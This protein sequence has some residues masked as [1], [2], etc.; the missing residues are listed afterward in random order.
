MFNLRTIVRAA[1]LALLLAPAGALAAPQDRV[2]L[3]TGEQQVGQVLGVASGQVQ[4]AIATGATTGRLSFRLEAISRVEAEPPAAFREGVAAFE[5]GDFEKALRTLQPVA[6]GF[7]GLPTDWARQAAALLG[8]LYVEKGDLARAEAA[9]TDYAKLYGGGGATGSLRTE[10]GAARLALAKQDFPG[11]RRRLEPVVT[12]ALKDPVKISRADAAA[13]GQACLLLGQI[14]ERAGDN[15]SALT[16]Y[17]RTV[18]LFYQDR[19]TVTAAQKAAD[20]LRAAHPGLM[21]PP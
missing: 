5:A 12:A 3:K 15:P 9:Y 19:A 13:A 11:A 14:A 1:G 10:V 21:A 8:D 16:H 17:L 4:L 6:D 7:R 2:I 18:T 20:N